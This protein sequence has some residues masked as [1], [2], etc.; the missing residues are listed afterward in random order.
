VRIGMRLPLLGPTVRAPVLVFMR[1]GRMADDA[2]MRSAGISAA[3]MKGQRHSFHGSIVSRV[4][5]HGAFWD[6]VDVDADEIV[7][8]PWLRR[9]RVID[10]HSVDTV[11]FEPVMFLPFVW[12]TN[13]RFLRDGQDV[14]PKLFTPARKRGFRRVLHE[15]RWPVVDLLPMSN[16]SFIRGR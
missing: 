10:R 1:R 9:R 2:S 7:L 5:I 6:R 12:K 16:Q 8:R 13:V 15:L 14:V 4:W 3:S 11:G